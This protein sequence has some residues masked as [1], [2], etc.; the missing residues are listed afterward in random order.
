MTRFNKTALF[1]SALA[2]GL[3]GAALAQEATGG[4]ELQE[5]SLPITVI[6]MTGTSTE[7]VGP[8]VGGAGPMGGWTVY[9]SDNQVLGS[10]TTAAIDTDRVVDYIIFALPNGNEVQLDATGIARVGEDS[11]MIAV[12]EAEVLSKAIAPMTALE[13]TDTSAALENAAEA[14]GEAVAAEPLTET[15]EPAPAATN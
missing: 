14:K 3:S 5:H 2:L 1:A 13:F 11:V 12:S 10:I 6:D 15:N 7:L 8:S 9:S 4:G